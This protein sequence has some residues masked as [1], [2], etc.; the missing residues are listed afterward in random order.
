MTLKDKIITEALRQF[1]TKGFMSTST[2]DIIEAAGTSKGGLYNHFDNKEQ[3]FYEVLERAKLI[4]RERNLVGVHDTAR[5]LDKIKKI[6]ENYRDNYLADSTNFP[7]G[8]IFINFAIELN[9]QQP[10]LAEAV[11]DGL[12]KL[13]KMLKRL[14]DEEY[15]S[16]TLRDD[17]DTRN[18]VELLY[19]GLLGACV[20]FTS[21]KSEEG[22]NVTINSLIEYLDQLCK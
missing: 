8:C 20:A 11:N 21:E 7:G 19:S 15:A 9:D 13:K 4:W 12:V 5:P 3:L 1:S 2:A 6:L 14:L 22:L 18:V 16:G 17:V 10:A